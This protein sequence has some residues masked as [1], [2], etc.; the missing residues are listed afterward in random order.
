VRFF[1][2]YYGKKAA[3]LLKLQ[4][5]GLTTIKT[6]VHGLLRL[7]SGGRYGRPVVSLRYLATELRET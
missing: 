2:K 4:I 3:W 1:R 6:I 5:Y 7:A